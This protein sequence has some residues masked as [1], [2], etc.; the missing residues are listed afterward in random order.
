M[1]STEKTTQERQKQR[2]AQKKLRELEKEKA[3]KRRKQFD[4]YLAKRK[5]NREEGGSTEVKTKPET[6]TTTPKSDVFS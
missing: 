3:D 5:G 4:D 2:D 1:K 6:T